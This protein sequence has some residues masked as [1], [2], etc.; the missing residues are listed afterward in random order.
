MD[1]S[2]LHIQERP[3]RGLAAEFQKR[4][5]CIKFRSLVSRSRARSLT[6]FAGPVPRSRTVSFRA[7]ANESRAAHSVGCALYLS[8]G[9]A[10]VGGQVRSTSHLHL[11]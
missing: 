4:Q 11:R 7:G 10:T 1:V 6:L 2:V 9:G 5:L 3:Q 8:S